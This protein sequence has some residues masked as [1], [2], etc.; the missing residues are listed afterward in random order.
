MT[1]D[2]YP[3]ERNA[4]SRRSLG[5]FELELY[6]RFAN[7]QFGMS[8][9][10]FRRKY[11]ASNLQIARIARVSEPTVERW[12]SQGIHRRQPDRTQ[13]LLLGV[14]DFLWSHYDEIP[15]DLKD[16]ICPP[17]PQNQQPDQLISLKLME[18]HNQWT[19]SRL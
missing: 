9:Q 4:S 12:F 17:S 8:P 6:R 18:T 16:V 3:E 15:Q 1:S 2:Q 10:V 5:R 11:Q 19:R 7:C 13:T 14:M